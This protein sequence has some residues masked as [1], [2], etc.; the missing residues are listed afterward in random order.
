MAYSSLEPPKEI[1]HSHH[2]LRPILSLPVFYKVLLA[3][4]LIIFLVPRAAP[5]WRPIYT[6]AIKRMLLRPL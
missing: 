2:L 1:T 4:S 3:N 6:I 5:G